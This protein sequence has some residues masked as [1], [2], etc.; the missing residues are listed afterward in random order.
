[1]HR[2]VTAVACAALLTACPADPEEDAP[3]AGTDAGEDAAP[4][5]RTPAERPDALARDAGRDG[6]LVTFED[7][8]ADLAAR[9]C[10]RMNGCEPFVVKKLF[11]TT[12]LCVARQRLACLASATAAGARVM[13]PL[14]AQCGRSVDAASC[15]DIVSGAALDACFPDGSRADNLPCAV[16]A[17]CASSYCQLRGARCGLCRPRGIA[18]AKCDP[19]ED[20][21]CRAGLTCAAAGTCTVPG[22]TGAVCNADARPC[23]PHLRCVAGLCMLPSPAGAA[24][25]GDECDALFGLTCIKPA[26]SPRGTCQPLKLAAPGERC[27]IVSTSVTVCFAAATCEQD[28]TGM[29]RCVAAAADGQPCGS[30]VYPAVCVERIC[31]VPSSAACN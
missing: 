24:C 25:V 5:A 27:G 6:G 23:Q 13:A 29:L 30:C 12:A 16:N 19:Q 3:E 18:G 31:R 1:M 4:D 17:Q 8:C 20:G 21:P 14:L 22:A 2:L 10:D 7:A 11:G 15:P 28:L 9:T 26:G